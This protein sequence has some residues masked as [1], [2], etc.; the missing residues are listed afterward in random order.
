[1]SSRWS[2]CP[3]TNSV[4]PASTA[5]QPRTNAS[6]YRS[7][8]SG[9]RTSLMERT[10]SPSEQGSL[11]RDV[12]QDVLDVA[13]HR[14]LQPHVAPAPLGEEPPVLEQLVEDLGGRQLVP[15]LARDGGDRRL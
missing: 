3:W 7:R 13:P 6:A 12:P 14:R 1:M 2:G 8:S 9:R 4:S 11:V 10:L 5:R 15:D